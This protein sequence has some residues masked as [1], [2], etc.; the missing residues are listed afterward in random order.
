MIL[1]LNLLITQNWFS[2]EKPGIL[3]LNKSN[4]PIEELEKYD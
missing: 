1:E 3:F 4:I 2:A